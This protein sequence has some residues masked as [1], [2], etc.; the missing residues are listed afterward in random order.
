MA[1]HQKKRRREIPAVEPST[2]LNA[3]CP[4]YTMFP[5]EFPISV[6]R[7]FRQ[8]RLRVLDPFCGRGTTIFA[9]RLRGHEAYGIDCSPIAI[10]IARAKLAETTDA[11]VTALA[12]R[13]LEEPRDVMVPEGVF[14]K[15]AYAPSTLREVCVLREG[16]RG[17]RTDAAHMLR[18]ICLGAL[19]GPLTLS[20]ETRSYFSN[21][22]PRTFA[23]KPEYSVRF[24]KA[25]RLRPVPV[26]VVK[27]I[28]ARIARLKLDTVPKCKGASKVSV[29]DSRLAR[30]YASVSEAIDLVVTSPPYYGMRTYVA[31]QWLRN[32]FLGGLPE[33]PY[34]EENPL[35][36][37]SPDAF[38]ESLAQV[39]DRIGDRLSSS[40]RMFIRFGAIPSRKANPRTIMFAS[41]EQSR[42]SWKVRR[43]CRAESASSGKRQ[44]GHMGDR[45]KSEAIAEYDYEVSL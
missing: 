10:A 6:M 16:L 13:I 4:Y 9:A 37:R 27:I 39:W 42:F 3:V 14:W 34:G 40:G 7:K 12:E 22:M 26:D 36:H 17:L 35:S 43:V 23:S 18:A 41:L 29:A 1:D 25:K 32:W 38:A 30:G 5:L 44:A 19:H 21:Q 45:V 2:T 28:K 15:W 33:V 11:D 24:W 20:V 8:K 31:D